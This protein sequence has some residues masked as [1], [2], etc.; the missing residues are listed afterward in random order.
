MLWNMIAASGPLVG[1]KKVK[2]SFIKFH[3]K[4]PPPTT[5]QN[6]TKQIYIYIFGTAAI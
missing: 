1:P 4:K 6:K 2:L 3:E 5:K